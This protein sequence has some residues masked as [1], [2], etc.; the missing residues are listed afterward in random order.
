MMRWSNDVLRSTPHCV[1]GDPRL[2]PGAVE[3]ERYSLV[4]FTNPSKDTVVE[5][6]PTCSSEESPPR[7]PPINAHEYV[8]GRIRSRMAATAAAHAEQAA[9]RI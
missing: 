6:L 8:V 9:G 3:P 7:Y 4:F 5:C 1:L 2:P